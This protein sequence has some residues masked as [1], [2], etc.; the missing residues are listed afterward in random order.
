M[1]ATEPVFPLRAP[2]CYLGEWQFGSFFAKIPRSPTIKCPFYRPFRGVGREKSAPPLAQ[3]PPPPYAPE[4]I[5]PLYRA[6]YVRTFYMWQLPPCVAADRVRPL[7]TFSDHTYPRSWRT[8]RHE[9]GQS[10]QALAKLCKALLSNNK[11]Y[12]SHKLTSNLTNT[13]HYALPL[14]WARMLDAVG[15]V[16]QL[17][18]VDA[19]GTTDGRQRHVWLVCA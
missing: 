9:K 12:N 8:M 19:C 3:Q 4:A 11:L 1:E 18:L 13:V 5:A 17:V 15:I 16:R 14:L 6:E 10:I 2:N 7:P